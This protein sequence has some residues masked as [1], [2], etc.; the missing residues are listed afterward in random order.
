MRRLLRTGGRRP[1]AA[2]IAAVLLAS[3]TGSAVSAEPAQ[4]RIGGTGS[5]LGGLQ[6]LVPAF[7]AANPDFELTVLPSL[8]SGGG[9]KALLAD[10]IEVSVSARPLKEQEAAAGLH[11]W[12]YARTPL[13]FATRPDTPVDAVT[14]EDM[15]AVYA[16]ETTTW[17]DG[18]RLR[19]VMRPEA[20]ADTGFLRTLSPGM[21]K[22]VTTATGNP[23]LFVAINDQDNATALEDIPGSVGLIALGQLQSEGRDLK[24]LALD[25]VAPTTDAFRK[26][27][28]PHG[29]SLYLMSRSGIS[30]PGA[31]RFLAFVESA[32]AQQLLTSAGYLATGADP[33]P[34]GGAAE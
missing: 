27:D 20:E 1:R 3:V 21:D 34:A 11:Q 18:S 31:E 10:S 15:T 19:L 24:P 7:N 28:Y 26:G 33:D 5:A 25:G 17:P 12:E 13:V 23:A 9:I 32:E 30:D 14:L 2:A 22:A 16:N 8:G 6:L 29:K 4:I